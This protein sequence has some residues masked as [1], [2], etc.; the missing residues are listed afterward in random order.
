MLDNEFD[1]QFYDTITELPEVKERCDGADPCVDDYGFPRTREDCE[2]LFRAQDEF[3]AANLN[4][5]N[6]VTKDVYYDASASGATY[7]DDTS[8]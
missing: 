8:R 4:T 3:I 7:Y 6:S 5:A 2:S 1:K